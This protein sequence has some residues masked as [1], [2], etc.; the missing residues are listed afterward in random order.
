MSSCTPSQ[1][2]IV[3]APGRDLIV[4]NSLFL[5]SQCMA[6]LGSLTMVGVRRCGTQD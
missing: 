4:D 2:T 5:G 3:L 6:V 1:A